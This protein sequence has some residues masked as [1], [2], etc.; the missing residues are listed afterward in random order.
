MDYLLPYKKNKV[1]T[2]QIQCPG[3]FSTIVVLDGCRGEERKSACPLVFFPEIQGLRYNL[4]F[5][6]GLSWVTRQYQP[7][8]SG[9]NPCPNV[10]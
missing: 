7:L 6:L 10:H 3:S 1:L 9:T 5:F 8:Y 2:L 4:R